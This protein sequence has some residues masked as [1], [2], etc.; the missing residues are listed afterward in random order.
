[1]CS[2]LVQCTFCASLLAIPKQ[3]VGLIKYQ[4]QNDLIGMCPTN[5]AELIL[6]L[7][8]TNI[9]I[10]IW[11]NACVVGPKYIRQMAALLQTVAVKQQ[12]AKRLVNS[13]LP[14]LG[15]VTSTCN[16]LFLA[17]CSPIHGVSDPRLNNRCNIIAYHTLKFCKN[18]HFSDVLLSNIIFS[19]L[20]FMQQLARKEIAG[21]KQATM[22]CSELAHMHR[23]CSA[24]PIRSLLYCPPAGTIKGPYQQASKQLYSPK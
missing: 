19:D 20:L 10:Q 11:K 8:K 13:H 4:T 9:M 14:Q 2:Q 3:H 6:N 18:P 24:T 21:P 1:M 7:Y 15:P 23:V 17:L 16:N 22:M 5:A 12:V